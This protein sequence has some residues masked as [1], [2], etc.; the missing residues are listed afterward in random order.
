MLMQSPTYI[1]P[2]CEFLSTFSFDEHALLLKFYLGNVKHQLGLFELSDVFH[3][4]KNQDANI[5]YDRDAFWREITG[6]LGRRKSLEF[7]HQL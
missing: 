1:R 4:S 5:E 2:T 6:R 7:D 3:F